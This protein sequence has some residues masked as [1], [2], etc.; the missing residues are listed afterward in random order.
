M[1]TCERAVISQ[2][3]LQGLGQQARYCCILFI[4]FN[5][6]F[7]QAYYIR[8]SKL[9]GRKKKRQKYF[10]N[11]NFSFFFSP[12]AE[13]FKMTTSEDDLVNTNRIIILPVEISKE[14]NTEVITTEGMFFGEQT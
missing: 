6:I 11:L 8:L 4:S 7:D 14:F 13:I 2:T 12:R 1:V 9:K 10:R 3:I 5:L